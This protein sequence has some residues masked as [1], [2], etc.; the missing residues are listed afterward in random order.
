[1]HIS[2]FVEQVVRNRIDFSLTNPF[3]IK[4]ENGAATG[5]TISK[6]KCVVNFI[7]MQCESEEQDLNL[8]SSSDKFV[9]SGTD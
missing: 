1:M 5:R 6:M 9:M 4:G 7:T 3:K 2:A 8:W